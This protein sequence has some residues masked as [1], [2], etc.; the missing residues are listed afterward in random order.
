VLEDSLQAR[1]AT[2][3]TTPSE[4]HQFCVADYRLR[5]VFRRFEVVEVV[6]RDGVTDRGIEF[7]KV[8]EIGIRL[9][10]F[11]QLPVA[12]VDRAFD[13]RLAI[14]VWV[15]LDSR[16]PLEA[17]HLTVRISPSPQEQTDG[18]FVVLED[19]ITYGKSQLVRNSLVRLISFREP[20]GWL[21]PG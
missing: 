16:A 4:A 1:S 13:R 10:V 2:R 14:L 15:I 20:V 9:E 5:P 7:G 19:S 8:I 11:Q 17:R 21:V 3:P 18:L 6:H 12:H